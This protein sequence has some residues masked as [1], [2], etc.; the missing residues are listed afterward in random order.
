[1]VLLFAFYLRQL[2]SLP[3][4]CDGCGAP[5]TVTHALDSSIGD[6]V[7]HRHNEACDTFGDL[8]SLVW[9]PVQQEPI[10]WESTDEVGS[11]LI[12]DLGSPSARPYLI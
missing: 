3:H 12:A 4:C 10:V 5:F 7:I 1:M 6:L 8:A 11:T 2:L 9:S